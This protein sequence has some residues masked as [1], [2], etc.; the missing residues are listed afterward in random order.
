MQWS[1]L[2]LVTCLSDVSRA[3][4][5]LSCM[6]DVTLDAERS[7]H[8]SSTVR[9]PDVIVVGGASTDPNA[10]EGSRSPDGR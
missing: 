1:G 5:L 9:F 10:C 6:M 2:A 3:R 7:R 4:S 8:E